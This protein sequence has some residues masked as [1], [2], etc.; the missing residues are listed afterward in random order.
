[1]ARFGSLYHIYSF[2]RLSVLAR[3]VEFL[4]S[5]IYPSI[6]SQGYLARMFH[7]SPAATV[8]MAVLPGVLGCRNLRRTV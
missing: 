1:M 8:D 5:E 2:I 3:Y 6:L 4:S 7:E